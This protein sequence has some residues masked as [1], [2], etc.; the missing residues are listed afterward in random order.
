MNERTGNARISVVEIAERPSSR[1][2]DCD[3][4]TRKK[5]R[6]KRKETRKRRTPGIRKFAGIIPSVEEQLRS[7]RKGSQRKL[8]RRL[9]RTRFEG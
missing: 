8:R 5:E 3:W 7:K 6:M 9:L 4:R 1:C 2:M